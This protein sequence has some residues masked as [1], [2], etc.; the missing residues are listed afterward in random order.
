MSTSKRQRARWWLRLRRKL[1]F[2]FGAL[3]LGVILLLVTIGPWLSPYGEAE[4]DLYNIYA[5]PGSAHW[6]GTDE[7]GRDLLT[8]VLFGG[9]ISL[10]VGVVGALVSL[11]IGVAVGGFA[12]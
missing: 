1:G 10:A 6:F 7:L 8:R 9:R 11:T 12:G 4:P 2:W 5:A 3:G